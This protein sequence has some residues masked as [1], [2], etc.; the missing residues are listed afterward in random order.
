[1]HLHDAC[2]DPR[3]Q[4]RRLGF[5]FTANHSSTSCLVSP[6]AMIPGQR[7]LDMR[8]DRTVLS[9]ASSS[10]ACVLGPLLSHASSF[11]ACVLRN[12]S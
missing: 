11:V 10:V 4:L 12:M 1:M 9:H 8:L 5:F 3:W 7:H 6:S 2:V